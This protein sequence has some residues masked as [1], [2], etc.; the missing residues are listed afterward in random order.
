MNLRSVGLILM[1]SFALSLIIIGALQIA[2][3]KKKN[4]GAVHRNGR[5]PLRLF[6]GQVMLT[7]GIIF[8][9][10]TILFFVVNLAGWSF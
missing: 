3:F 1:L 8:T 7:A 5:L 10:V 4:S 9:F 2:I 6:T